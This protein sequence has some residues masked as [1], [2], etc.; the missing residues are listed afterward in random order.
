MTNIPFFN[1]P[2]L[3]TS[4][5]SD[6][7]EIF[8]DVGRRGAF[9]LGEDLKCFEKEIADYVGVSY[10]VGVNNATDGLHFALKAGGIGHGDEVIICS[11]T[12]QATAA[13]IQA[14]GAIPVPVEVGADRC[15]DVSCITPAIN[16]NTKAIMPTNLNGRVC[17]MDSIIDICSKFNLKLFEDAAQAL[18]AKYKNKKAG[19]FGIASAISFYPAKTLGC[20][21][22]GGVVLT[23]D[24]EVYQSILELRSFG[25]GSE[26]ECNQWA[27]NSRL[28]NF[29]AAI[30]RFKM[31]SYARVIERRREIAA[32]YNQRLSGIPHI[33]LPPGP[34]VSGD[35]FDIFQNY[36]IEAIQRDQLQAYLHKAGVGTLIQW[37][38]RAIHSRK[39]LG[40]NQVL[41]RT[42]L[43]FSKCLMLPLNMSITNSEVHLVC[44]LLHGFY[45][46]K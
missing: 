21:G 2:A 31:K 30:L 20:F 13:A 46:A 24:R 44:D 6:F 10:A 29:Q 27:L 35:W 3:F 26:G 39:K 38:G 16:K 15:I 33:A 45:D 5:E 40:F 1:Y 4:S 41:P 22:D 12:M 28:D 25:I 11:H 8:R 43:F 32:I 34:E 17:D 19:S 37:N 23:N 7:I 18:G 14:V 36:E 42:D 9:I